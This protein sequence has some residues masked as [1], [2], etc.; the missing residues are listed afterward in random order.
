SGTT[1]PKRAWT[2]SCDAITEARTWQR[3]STTAAAVSSQEVSIARMRA[4]TE[5]GGRSALTEQVGQ[6]FV[7]GRPGDA[8]IGDD[9]GDQARGG[10]VEGGVQHADPLRGDARAADLG[11]LARVAL[12]DRDRVPREARPIDRGERGRDVEGDPVLAR[13]HRERVRPDLVRDFAVSRDA[14]GAHDDEVHPAPP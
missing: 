9:R 14:V 10:D 7:E 13:E 2:S 11:D 8:A 4:T 12:L 5:H 6:A 3:S 1:P